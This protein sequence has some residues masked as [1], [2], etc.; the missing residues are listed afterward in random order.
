MQ[1]AAPAGPPPGLLWPLAPQPDIVRAAQKVR[2]AAAR[3]GP[4]LAGERRCRASAAL[5]APHTSPPTPPPARP[6]Q[7]TLYLDHVLEAVQ[8]AVMRTL[9]PLPAMQYAR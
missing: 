5:P 6:A 7:D 2:H 8:D 3:R 9:G 1:S 4:A